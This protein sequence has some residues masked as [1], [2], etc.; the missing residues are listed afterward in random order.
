MSKTIQ[1][2]QVT[3][4]ELKHEILK[5]LSKQLEELKKGFSTNAPIDYLSRADVAKMLQ[6]DLSTLYIWTKKGV[7]T[8]YGIGNR[9]YYKREEVEAAIIRLNQ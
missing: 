8:S 7:L 4:E 9:V 3:P 1:F 2:L 5:G 6:I